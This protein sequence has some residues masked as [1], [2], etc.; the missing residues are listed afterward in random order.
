MTT[1]I[2]FAIKLEAE[3]D[4][5]TDRAA[6]YEIATLLEHVAQQLMNRARG[7]LLRDHG[8]KDVGRWAYEYSV[9]N[10]QEAQD[11]AA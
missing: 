4:N 3:Y 6:R 2:R 10:E 1:K 5:V 11:D 7:G 9:T 8:A